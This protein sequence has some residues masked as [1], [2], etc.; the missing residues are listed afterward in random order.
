[1]ATAK[2]ATAPKYVVTS[3][4]IKY[5]PKET[6]KSGQSNAASWSAIQRA[7]K[8]GPQTIAALQKAVPDTHKNFVQYAVRR[9][10]L[11]TK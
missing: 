5:S 3:K 4:G 9:Q 11:A 6:C 1:M 10:W 2:S 7:C 8:K